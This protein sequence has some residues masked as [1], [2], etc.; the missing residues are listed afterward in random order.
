MPA[1]PSLLSPP[2]LP[3]LSLRGL[4]LLLPARCCC[5]LRDSL[6]SPLSGLL[7]AAWTTSL[8]REE[9]SGAETLLQCTCSSPAVAGGVRETLPLML[10]RKS[11]AGR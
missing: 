5:W 10:L 11:C 4:L 3:L 1:L 6:L 7:T 2:L 8:T 9:V